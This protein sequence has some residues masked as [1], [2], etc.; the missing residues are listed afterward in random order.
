MIRPSQLHS[1]APK[2]V[3]ASIAVALLIVFGF[4]ARQTGID[5]A[6]PPPAPDHHTVIAIT[7]PYAPFFDFHDGGGQEWQLIAAA[8]R[9]EGQQPEY[10]YGSYEDAMRYA[11]TDYVQGVWV[12]GGMRPPE[13]GYYPSVPLLRRNFVVAILAARD[14]T[15]NDPAEL[16]PLDV[17]V[18]PDVYRALE[19]QIPSALSV[20]EN[21]R[22][23]PNHVF[24]ATQLLV[25]QLDAVITEK[26]VF[27]EALRQVPGDTDINQQINY[28]QVFEPLYPR[29]L[30]KD[31]GLRDRFNDGWKKVTNEG[32]EEALE[33]GKE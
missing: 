31:K 28:Q 8:L 23:I 30:F 7:C 11:S 26:A 27:I 12:C 1:L 16:L 2:L 19:P 18:H 10:V 3:A 25:G 6:M 13:E 20:S 17:G 33:H 14:L 32:P 21:L 5:A 29:I 15:V 4:F 9:L 24:L 22:K